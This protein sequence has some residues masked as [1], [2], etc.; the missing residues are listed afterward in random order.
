MAFDLDNPLNQ[1][2]GISGFRYDSKT[3]CC[4]TTPPP[5]GLSCE[6]RLSLPNSPASRDTMVVRARRLGL[7]SL[8]LSPDV[9][10]SNAVSLPA[11]TRRT[12]LAALA[13]PVAVAGCGIH[14]R[15]AIA[16]AGAAPGQPPALGPAAVA[17]RY[18]GVTPTQWGT[19][20]PGVATTFADRFYCLEPVTC[21]KPRSVPLGESEVGQMP[22]V[23]TEAST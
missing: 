3:A 15:M 18:R 11:I 1:Q 7:Y 5:E 4:T 14:D 10:P 13:G 9:V 19:S 22:R 16:R 8:P 23:R 21:R 17:A 6:P 2:S 20:L 12:F